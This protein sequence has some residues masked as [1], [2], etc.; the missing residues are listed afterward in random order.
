MRIWKV[1]IAVVALAGVAAFSATAQT[2]TMD[3]ADHDMGAM[4]GTDMD[5]DMATMGYSASAAP[6]REPGQGAFAAIAEIVAALAA[7]PETDWS[8]VDIDGLRAH[9]ADMDLV[10]TR[11]S[12]VSEA[13]DGGE[14]FDV[15]GTGA[16]VGA[17]Q[18]MVLAHAAVMNGADGWQMSA[19]PTADGATLE[20][21][22]PE[23]D[24]AKLRSLGFFGVLAMGMHHQAHHWMIAT[25]QNPHT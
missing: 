9:L 23:A 6:V 24:Q 19:S 10:T 1:G 7:D 8:S 11:A 2:M 16:V 4:M 17:V 14:R 15:T 20:V 3:H 21:R 12:A 13:I 5:H 25:G 18:R 22:V